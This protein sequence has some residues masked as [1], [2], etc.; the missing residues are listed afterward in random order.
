MLDVDGHVINPDVLLDRVQQLL[1]TIGGESATS[2]DE[3]YPVFTDQLAAPVHAMPPLLAELRAPDLSGAKGI[4][5]RTG[6]VFKRML[7]RL[8]SWYVEP[9]WAV[10]QEFDVRGMEFSRQAIG[11]FARLDAELEELRRQN[12]RLR[13]QIV[14]EIERHNRQRKEVREVLKDMASQTEL[15]SLSTAV[16]RLD[17]TGT[18]SNEID[19]VEFEDRC[20][21][22]SESIKHAQERY[23]SLF[24][25]PSGPGAIIDI[26][27][28]RGEMLQLLIA[29]GYKTVG[30]DMDTNMIELCRSKGLPVVQDNGIHYLSGTED[31]S[32]RGIFCAQVVEHLLTPELERLIELCHQK[33]MQSAVVVIETINPRS[34]FALGNHFFADVSHTRPVHPETLRFICEQ[35][36]FSKVQ[37]EERSPHPFMNSVDLLPEG[38]VG[39]ALRELLQNVFGYQDYVIVAT[40]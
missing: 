1:S 21:G 14:A 3:T 2:P 19:Y 8:T 40:K 13:L 6:R 26:G 16:K 29:A 27:C 4:R 23:L 18:T 12:V 36:G 9:R 30:V 33:L 11:A 37:L 17:V 28:G 35:I 39:I 15:Q 32:L 24:P 22:S 7:R 5:G 34:L 38:E 31:N 10:Q 25:A 20:R